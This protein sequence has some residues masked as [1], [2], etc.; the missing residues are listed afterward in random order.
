MEGDGMKVLFWGTCG[1]LPASVRAETVRRKIAA[2]IKGL[3]G[4]RLVTDEEI[5]GFITRDLPFSTA[6]TY[7]T[8]TSCVEIT[9][10]GEYLLCDAGTG[11]RDFGNH[12]LGPGAGERPERPE[13]FNIFLSHLHWDHIQGFP[14]FT[15][16][17][18]E[19]RRITVYG[20]HEEI[21]KSLA[22]QQSSPN[23]P[24]PLEFMKADIRFRRL[25]PGRAY[26]VA[27]FRVT[28]IAQNHPGRSYG[29]RFEKAGRS[30]V[31]STD[32]EH[33]EDAY[34]E[35]YDFLRFFRGADLLIFDAQYDLLEAIHTK[36]NWGHSS[37]IIGVELSVRA[38][39]KHLCLYH[40]EPTMNDEK[41]DTFLEETQRYASHYAASYP[42]KISLA[43]DGLVI[44]LP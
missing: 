37:N 36:E 26:N 29:Y 4:R 28:C 38:G 1:S 15:P 7:G 30:V 16:A 25:K 32:S 2:A 3:G 43:Y 31:Y 8:N 11:L 27:G 21:E 5:E 40:N 20:G 39:V 19:G 34:R 42:L 12:V 14:F 10:G 35:D 23:F 33:K 41:L 17:Y 13:C 18:L 9:G 6:G 24:V 44:E 22:R